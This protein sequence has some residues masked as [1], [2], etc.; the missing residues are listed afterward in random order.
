MKD[1][2]KI[3]G[4]S[5]DASADEIKKAFRKLAVKHHPD[6]GGDEKKFK[7]AN[8]AYDTLKS[9]SKKQEYDT[10][11]RF[12][13][14]MGG[15]GS[16]F[17][18]HTGNFNEFF[19]GDFFEEFMSGMGGSGQRQRFRQRQRV[20]K[21]VSIR[22][23]MSIKEI[24]SSVKRTISVKLPSGRDEIVDVK[25]GAG[26]QNGVVLKYSGLGDDSNS[27]LPRGNLLIRV[28]ILDSDGFTRKGNDIWTDKTIDAFDAMRGTEFQIKDLQ[29]NIIKVKVPAGTQPGSV[30][31][32]KSKGMPV[33]ES[34]S[35]RGNMYIKIHITIP[36]LTQQQLNKIKDL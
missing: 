29:E 8:E 26:I 11:R 34:L 7:E 16:G 15:Q 35:I 20:N 3:L 2:Y 25:I 1:Y 19:G 31:Q 17:K 24:M 32:L 27:N 18:F 6:R 21:D 12:G 10:M 13:S 23:T 14:N 28:T 30:L 33:H 5:E 9:E 22:I 36:T 4:V